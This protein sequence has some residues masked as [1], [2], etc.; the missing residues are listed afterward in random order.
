M[1]LDSS[2]PPADPAGD[3]LRDVEQVL[4]IAEADFDGLEP[5]A[6]L[7]KDRAHAVDQNVGDPAVQEQ[8]LDRSPAL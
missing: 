6:A 3:P 4:G 7:D 1:G 2:T 8:R 5:A